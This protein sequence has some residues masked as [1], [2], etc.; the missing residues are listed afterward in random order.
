LDSRVH[1]DHTVH[2]EYKEQLG[3]LV[4]KDVL[5]SPETKGTWVP[6]VLQVPK[7]PR[8]PKVPLDHLETKDVPEPPE[9]KEQ[10]VPLGYVGTKGT[11]VLLERKDPTVPPERMETKD[12]QGPL[13]RKDR[14]DHQEDQGRPG[15]EEQKDQ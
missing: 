13:E 7:V 10:K 14:K 12:V 5:E 3:H 15:I 2:R 6:L 8:V 1:K 9:R 11:T 4:T